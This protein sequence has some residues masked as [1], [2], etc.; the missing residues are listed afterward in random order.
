MKFVFTFIIFNSFSFY[1][2]NEN[3]HSRLDSLVYLRS[4]HESDRIAYLKNSENF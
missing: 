2:R 3:A 1:E 4:S